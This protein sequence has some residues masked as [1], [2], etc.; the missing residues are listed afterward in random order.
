MVCDF[1]YWLAPHGLCGPHLCIHYI[2]KVDTY[3]GYTS[4]IFMFLTS[5]PKTIDPLSCVNLHHCNFIY[6]LFINY[7][8]KGMFNFWLKQK[9]ENY[10]KFVYM[11]AMT[12]LNLL[13]P[14]FQNCSKIVI[15]S[16]HYLLK[17]L[18]RGPP[19]N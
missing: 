11:N 10:Y 19:R 5:V 16:I 9:N 12:L 2:K 18:K 14:T 6:L 3:R 4:K 1:Y 7:S 15:A 17:K 8:F 13:V